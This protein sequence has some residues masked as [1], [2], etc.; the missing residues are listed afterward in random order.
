MKCRCGGQRTS[1]ENASSIASTILTL[2][3]AGVE[4]I[5][6]YYSAVHL[7]MGSPRFVAASG[8]VVVVDRGP[9]RRTPHQ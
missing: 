7:E 2:T 3:L 4:L 1:E 9:V 6:A 5:G 8:S